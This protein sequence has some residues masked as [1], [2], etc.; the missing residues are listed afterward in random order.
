MLS[1]RLVLR[2]LS[3]TPSKREYDRVLP[4]AMPTSSKLGLCGLRRLPGEEPALPDSESSMS[5]FGDA[6]G[7]SR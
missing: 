4:R 5:Q 7:C 6:G 1:V 3:L 2:S